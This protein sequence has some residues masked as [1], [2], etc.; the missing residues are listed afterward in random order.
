MFA[1]CCTVA[2]IVSET[3]TSE[4]TLLP[5]R[6]VTS[7]AS[8]DSGT[9]AYLCKRGCKRGCK[10]PN[11]T[12]SETAQVGIGRREQLQRDRIHFDMRVLQLRQQRCEQLADRVPAEWVAI[13]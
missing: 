8:S 1:A 9:I 6:C 5:M 7:S 3:E 2:H 13:A 4:C 10:L 11:R 12:A